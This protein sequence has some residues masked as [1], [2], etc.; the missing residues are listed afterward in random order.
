MA[1][2]AARIRGVALATM[3]GIVSASVGGCVSLSSAPPSA[4]S[5]PP[6]IAVERISVTA[7]GHFV[8]LRYRVTDL[9]AAR[10]VFTPK[11]MHRLT[12]EATGHVMLVPTTEK[13]GALRQTRGLKTGHTYFMLF[14]NGGLRPGSLVTAEIAGF[15]FP[16]LV[17]Q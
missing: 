17:V 9:E 11:A 14:V 12:D 15:R 1:G 8:D 4:P 7:A 10:T 5:P 6:P 3:A 16:H 2:V 13:L